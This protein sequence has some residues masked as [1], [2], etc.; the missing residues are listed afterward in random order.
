LVSAASIE[1]V[2]AG[3]ASA[4]AGAGAASAGAGAGVASAA[5]AATGAGSV[6]LSVLSSAQ[7]FNKVMLQIA[8]KKSPVWKRFL[9]LLVIEKDFIT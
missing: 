6:L 9:I 3:A 1:S 8:A 4:A 2:F 7:L 5:G